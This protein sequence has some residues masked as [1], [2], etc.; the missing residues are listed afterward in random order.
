MID[1]LMQI[2]SSASWVVS[3]AF[4][5]TGGFSVIASSLGTNTVMGT[6]K[7]GLPMGA[8]MTVQRS[9]A[10]ATILPIEVNLDYTT[11]GGTTWFRAGG[12][13]MPAA[14]GPQ[15]YSTPVGLVDFKPEAQAES[16]IGLRVIAQAQAVISGTKAPTISVWLGRDKS[17]SPTV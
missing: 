9:D 6:L 8:M 14:T 4:S 15:I 3:T 16:L 7:E 17:Y 13:S 5:T 12:V 2:V 11:D 1:K 10:L